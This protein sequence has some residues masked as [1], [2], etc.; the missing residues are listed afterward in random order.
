MIYTIVVL[1]A[2]WFLVGFL[3][4]NAQMD[5]YGSTAHREKLK[6]EVP[7]SNETTFSSYWYCIYYFLYAVCRVKKDTDLTGDNL[8]IAYK[9]FCVIAVILFLSALW[10]LH[11]LLS[12]VFTPKD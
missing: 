10:P 9:M 2:L 7:N 1:V 4:V 8:L 6:F 12:K 3:I 5:S 11:L